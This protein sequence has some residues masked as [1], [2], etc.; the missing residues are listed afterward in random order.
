LINIA[1]LD[2]S[3]SPLSDPFSEANAL[4]SAKNYV[5]HGLFNNVGL[6]DQCNGYLFPL[7]GFKSYFYSKTL[8]KAYLNENATYR[9]LA[10][11]NLAENSCV[12]THYPQGADLLAAFMT[13]L[14]GQN[15][16]D[17][18]RL[19]PLTFHFIG[20]FFLGYTIASL[21]GPLRCLIA[22]GYC[23]SLPMF[24]NMSIGLHYQGYA[25]ALL[26]IEISLLLLLFNDALNSRDR[27]IAMA[28][29]AFLGFFQGW[30]SFDY[31]FL[32]ILCPFA[33][34][35][36]VSQIT[37][38]SLKVAAKYSFLLGAGFTLAHFIHFLE[39]VAYFGSFEKAIRD[40]SYAA[41]KRSSELAPQFALSRGELVWI[42]LTEFSSRID[43]F[44][45]NYFIMAGVAFSYRL[46]LIPLEAYSPK[47]NCLS[48]NISFI[49]LFTVTTVSLTVSC[50][51]IVLMKGHS[52][53]HP[54]FIPR[55][56]FLAYFIPM[57][58]LLKSSLITA[59][60]K[61]DELDIK[62]PECYK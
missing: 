61:S 50:L 59:Y 42:Y 39:V 52:M 58:Y 48:K 56:L 2:N 33:L 24:Y 44:Q 4:R 54:H 11:I 12:Y 28:S 36:A 32:V 10:S 38:S 46:L 7:A 37:E 8:Q 6:P 29:L 13:A 19:L 55:H 25:F 5:D 45:I 22:L 40:F 53:E 18:Y 1:Q 51:W 30:L 26:L 23:F 43:Y 34:L 31:V 49:R 57:L 15:N 14:G 20:V 21:F 9:P 62:Q 16:I 35:P 17:I 60:N 47:I 27:H 3:L 41:V